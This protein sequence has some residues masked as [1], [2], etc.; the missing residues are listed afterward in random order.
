MKRLIGILF[1]LGVALFWLSPVLA[2]ATSFNPVISIVNPPKQD[3]A[4]ESVGS[5]PD[6]SNTINNKLQQKGYSTSSDSVPAKDGTIVAVPKY[7]FTKV[8]WDNT[9]K[10]CNIEVNMSWYSKLKT[11]DQQKVLAI[12]LNTIHDSKVTRTNRNKI[13]N[14][15]AS[16]DETTAS[17]VRQLSDD[18]NND[19]YTAYAFFKPFSSPL[20]T[21]LGVLAIAIF[22]LLVLTTLWDL[23]YLSFPLLQLGLSK[24]AKDGGKPATVSIEAY[25]ALKESE[26]SAN[27]N[28]VGFK[29]SAVAYFRHSTKKFV[30]LSVCLLYLVSGQ[31]FVLIGNCID[32]FR[33]L[34]S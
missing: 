12:A 24:T 1:M 10:V 6:M 22:L 34:V 17:I 3:C 2:K 14:E 8:I 29:S 20:G 23:A 25:A 30:A 28:G 31:I 4:S 9:T 13:Y 32:Y 21:L 16:L 7:E 33:G 18:V 15:L 5:I 27:S 19:F 26:A 11:A